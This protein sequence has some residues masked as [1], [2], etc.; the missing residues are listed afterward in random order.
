MGPVKGK[1]FRQ[2]Q[3]KVGV[4]IRDGPLMIVGTFSV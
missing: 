4:K 1:D 3:V 2:N